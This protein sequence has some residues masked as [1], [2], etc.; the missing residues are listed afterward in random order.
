MIEIRAS[1]IQA[2]LRAWVDERPRG[3][4]TM[5]SRMCD[6]KY[7][8][9]SKRNDQRAWHIMEV[10]DG[11]R[12]HCEYHPFDD[13]S[14]KFVTDAMFKWHNDYVALKG[15]IRIQFPADLLPNPPNH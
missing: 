5:E 15:K 11:Q 9:L 4:R 12:Y 7:C 8:V 14:G 3:M 6:C 10:V 1:I 13:E 2:N